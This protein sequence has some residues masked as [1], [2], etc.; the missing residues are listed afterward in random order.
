MPLQKSV[1]RLNMPSA[2]PLRAS[3]NVGKPECATP[4]MR[5]SI[6]RFPF[7]GLYGN[8]VPI[9]VNE[10]PNATE[11]G[12]VPMKNNVLSGPTL[13]PKFVMSRPLTAVDVVD[14]LML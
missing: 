13:L 7:A 10:D 9:K 3:K 2:V 11:A 14:R 5:M 6:S 12:S 1:A 4:E 8:G